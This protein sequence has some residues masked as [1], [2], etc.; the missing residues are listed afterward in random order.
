MTG[1]NVGLPC[2]S[3]T[4][5]SIATMR[6]RFRGIAAQANDPYGGCLAP[7]P[8]LHYALFDGDRNPG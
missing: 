3:R 1:T 7:L 4:Q 2:R 8:R 5:F 6:R